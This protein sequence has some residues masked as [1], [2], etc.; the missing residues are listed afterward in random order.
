MMIAE[1]VLMLTQDGTE[2]PVHVRIFAPVEGTVDWSCRAEIHWPEGLAVSTTYG[3]DSA[4]ALHL[5]LQAIGSRLYMSDAHK[6]GRLRW[7]EP[8]SGYGFPIIKMLRHE[9]IGDDARFDGND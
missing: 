3:L 7:G 1:R 8:G 5:T 2:V 6:E 9:L 4:Q